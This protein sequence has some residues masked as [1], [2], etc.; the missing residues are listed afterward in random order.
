MLRKDL[1][2]LE[3]TPAVIVGTESSPTLAPPPMTRPPEQTRSPAFGPTAYFGTTLVRLRL[4]YTNLYKHFSLLNL[5][6]STFDQMMVLFPYLLAG[7]LVFADDPARRIT[8]GTLM[9]LTNSFEKTF[10]SMNIVT[11]SWGSINE[12]RSTL[13]RLREFEA[14]LYAQDGMSDCLLPGRRGKKTNFQET[15]LVVEGAPVTNVHTELQTLPRLV[16]DGPVGDD[17]SDDV[18]TGDRFDNHDMRV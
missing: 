18:S 5:F 15:Q 12:F 3:T 4:N 11:E 13:R 1:V 17:P 10:S 7:P 14:K 2:L 16:G 6:L 8:L 9:K